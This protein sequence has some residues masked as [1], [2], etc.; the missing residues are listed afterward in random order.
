VP[1]AADPFGRLPSDVRRRIDLFVSR[2]ER[3]SVEELLALAARPLAPDDHARALDAVDAAARESGRLDALGRVR[4]DADEWVV[5]LY[6]RSTAQPGWY[7]A[8]WGR[9]GSSQDRANLATSLGEALGALVVWDRIDEADR[10][11]LLG[12]W[13][14]L[15]E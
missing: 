14:D 3:L 15:A 13:A 1:D 9:P 11:E 6:N 5:R 12:T 10:D 7:E 4:A 8:N 2:L